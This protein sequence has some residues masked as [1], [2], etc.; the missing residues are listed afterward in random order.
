L[1]LETVDAGTVESTIKAIKEL[2]KWKQELG[3][4]RRE[5][6]KKANQKDAP[7]W[8]ILHQVMGLLFP[9]ATEGSEE[10]DRLKISELEQ[11]RL[12]QLHLT[13]AYLQ[14]QRSQQNVALARGLSSHSFS[15]LHFC[16]LPQ[17][18]APA[19]MDRM[20]LRNRIH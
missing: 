8:G 4:Y 15:F 3:L 16:C 13:R 20:P 14:S 1:P 18:A 10:E 2:H 11:D 6:E 9:G 7:S 19:D 12:A 17:S 5:E